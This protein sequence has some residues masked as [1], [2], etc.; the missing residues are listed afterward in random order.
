MQMRE[1]KKE[2]EGKRKRE[3]LGTTKKGEKLLKNNFLYSTL[4]SETKQKLHFGDWKH[5]KGDSKGTMIASK[6]VTCFFPLVLLSYG[7]IL[8]IL[9]DKN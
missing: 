3:N 4:T 6:S 7:N 8:P 1:R 9:N 2:R 5:P